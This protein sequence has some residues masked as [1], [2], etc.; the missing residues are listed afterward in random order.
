MKNILLILLLIGF[1]LISG[2]GKKD[3]IKENVK[4]DKKSE[5]MKKDNTTSGDQSKVESKDKSTTN[6]NDL[7]ISEG[8]PKNFPGDIPQ[9][10]NSKCLGSLSSSEGTVVNFETSE[11]IKDLVDFYKDEMKK[12]GFVIAEGGDIIV[13]NDAAILSWKK[14][15][16]EFSLIMSF[17]KEKSMSQIAMTYK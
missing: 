15:A 4:D 9:P 11:K 10:K 1:V 5:E 2:C 8:L 6:L 16:R 13:S 14:D 12:V 17:D 7:G 3:D